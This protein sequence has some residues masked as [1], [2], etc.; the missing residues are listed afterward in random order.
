MLITH[1]PSLAACSWTHQVQGYSPGIQGPPRLCIVVPCMARSPIRCRHSKSPRNSLFL[2]RLPRPASSSPLD[3][4]QQS[5]F[6]CWP[7][8]VELPGFQHYVS[9]HILFGNRLRNPCPH[10]RSVATLP[11]P[12][13]VSNGYG[14]N[15]TRSYSNGWTEM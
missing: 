1:Q 11:F 5:L 3:C 2:Q 8:G 14:K 9:V 4:W 10:C 6:S 13:R 15:I 12:Y 7:S